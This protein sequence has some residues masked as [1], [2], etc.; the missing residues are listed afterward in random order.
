MG[1]VSREHRNPADYSLQALRPPVR[2][3]YPMQ[4]WAQQVAADAEALPGGL[5]ASV[6]H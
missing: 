3:R 6:L 2:D 1:S 4:V 5:N